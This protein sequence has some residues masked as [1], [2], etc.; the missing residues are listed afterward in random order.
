MSTHLGV[1]VIN[2]DAIHIYMDESENPNDPV[3]KVAHDLSFYL[4]KEKIGEISISA[5]DS[6]RAFLYNFTVSSKYRNRGY[7]TGIMKYVMSRYK[8][9]EL[10]VDES[11]VSAIRFY[12]RFGFKIVMRFT[13][14]GK[15]RV[16]MKIDPKK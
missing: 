10:T 4:D 15:K 6:D 13:E 11:N 3:G 5:V 8:V 1:I 7:G 16:D 2:N 12:K 9:N 14:G